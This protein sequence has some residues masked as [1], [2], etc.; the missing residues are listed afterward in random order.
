MKYLMVTNFDNH[1]DYV[2]NN[3]TSYTI[4]MI[5]W[6]IVKNNPVD[7]TET[8][9]IKRNK[10]TSEVE[11]CWIG[12]VYNFSRENIDRPKIH[13][14]VKIERKISCPEEYRN[15]TAGWY[16]L[17]ALEKL[18]RNLV[19][20][21]KSLDTNQKDIWASI[22]NDFEVTK[23]QFG[24]R[25]NF[26]R[27]QFKRDI[28][29]R[30]VEQAY[31]LAKEGFNKPAVILA[32]GVIEELLRLF[33]DNKNEN[34]KN[35]RFEELIKICQKKGF[36]KEEISNLASAIR[37]FRNSVHLAAEKSKKYTISK[38]TALATVALIFTIAND[39]Q[40]E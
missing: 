7:N 39:F 37:R 6:D 1:W 12:K 8:L 17:E 9:F 28:I 3:E 25:I 30:D 5:K 2:P 16:R 10:I 23:L 38:A 32:G 24:K 21:E 20:I 19:K 40:K 35:K 11:G 13:F 18:D 26:V 33:L 31:I 4:G 22:E 27:N 14:K 34:A 29:F 36:L 15:Y